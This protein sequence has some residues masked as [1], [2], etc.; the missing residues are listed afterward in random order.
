MTKKLN[1]SIELTDA[2][3][4]ALADESEEDLKPREETQQL[5]G[6]E[7]TWN[8]DP[9]LEHDP[10]PSADPSMFDTPT[11]LP[12]IAHDGVVRHRN[13]YEHTKQELGIDPDDSPDIP[14]FE[15][16]NIDYTKYTV[17]PPEKLTLRQALSWITGQSKDL[18]NFTRGDTEKLMA[19]I[20]GEQPI[21]GLI[22]TL[23]DTTIEVPK[24]EG[25][26]R[27]EIASSPKVEE[28]PDG[29]Q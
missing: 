26:G 16:W 18:T 17:T 27:T 14:E 1:Q 9:D 28:S 3:I 24:L 7:P 21:L 19:R 29:N 12:P 11:V 2:D 25:S 22:E 15:D 5:D 23:N 13:W 4:E 8:P 6:T 10:G 20:R